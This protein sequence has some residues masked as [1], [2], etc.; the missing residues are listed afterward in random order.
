[1]SPTTVLEVMTQAA[2]GRDDVSVCLDSILL[3][4]HTDTDL[5]TPEL[6]AVVA[7]FSNEVSLLR[8][9][10]HPRTINSLV[11]ILGTILVTANQSTLFR[12]W[13]AA[14]QLI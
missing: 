6:E 2:Q 11:C 9:Y 7:A 5:G 4:V 13:L 8:Q 12:S 1:M 3:N 14:H 10:S